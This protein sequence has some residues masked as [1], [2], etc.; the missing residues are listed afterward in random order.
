MNKKS[1][2]NIHIRVSPE[3]HEKLRRL[4]FEKRKSIT[5]LVK[6]AIEK[7]YE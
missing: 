3:L 7:M 4:A 1:P 5:E 2:Y 6:K